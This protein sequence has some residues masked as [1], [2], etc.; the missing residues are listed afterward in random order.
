MTLRIGTGVLKIMSDMFEMSLLM[1]FCFARSSANFHV[2]DEVRLCEIWLAD[3]ID[4]VSEIVCD[5]ERSF[6]IGWP[7]VNVVATFASIQIRDVWLN[8]L[9]Q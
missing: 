2:K 1:S 9:Q 3:C 8:R 4:Q 6:V 7:T 5:R